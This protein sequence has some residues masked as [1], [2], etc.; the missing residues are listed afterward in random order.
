MDIELDS[1]ST[2]EQECAKKK[3]NRKTKGEGISKGKLEVRPEESS[4]EDKGATTVENNEEEEGE[5]ESGDHISKNDRYSGSQDDTVAKSDDTGSNVGSSNP[6]N[7]D[8]NVELLKVQ[9]Q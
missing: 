1:D 3:K 2:N 9:R 5:I 4:E 6:E 7:K 8:P